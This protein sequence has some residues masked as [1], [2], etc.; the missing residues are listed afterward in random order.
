MRSIFL[1]LFLF[2]TV[3]CKAQQTSTDSSK[4]I[5]RL[6]V[7]VISKGK[8]FELL[9]FTVNVRAFVKSIFS[10]KKMRVVIASKS[11]Y[12]AN[13]ID[14]L[15]KKHHAKIGNLWFDSHGLYKNGFSSFSIGEDNF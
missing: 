15:M 13:K 7:Y 8:K 1:F 5:T 9:P 6:N 14:R 2:V 3:F 12:A 4:K 10:K 11:E